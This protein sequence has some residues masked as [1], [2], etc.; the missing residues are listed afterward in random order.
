MPR[1]YSKPQ[2]NNPIAQYNKSSLTA[3]LGEKRSKKK[4]E[5]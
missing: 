3:Y 4:K 2:Q 1:R 5:G